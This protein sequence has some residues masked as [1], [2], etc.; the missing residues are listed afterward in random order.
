MFDFRKS[1]ATA[2]AVASMAGVLGMAPAEAQTLKVVMHS[3][4]KIL[5][6]IWTTAYIQ[7]NHGYMVWDTLF[8]M[9]EKFQAKPQMVDKYEVSADKLTWTI[10]LR[11][12]LVWSD[13]TP[14]TSDD[15][16][17]SIKRWGARDAFGQALMKSTGELKKVDDKSFAIVL[18]EP[19]GLVLEAL[20]K[21]SSNVPF[22]MPKRV[23]ETDPYK[24]ITDYTGSGP[25]I[26][27]KDEWKPGDKVVFVKNPK[28][29]P[30]SEPPSMLA[31]GKVA[32][33]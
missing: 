16:I 13:G 11:D 6:P 9:D 14:V 7:R 3:D 10:T 33:V 29:K 25:F 31:G 27:K 1:I 17:A 30:R 15:C 21:I 26:F 32:K 19:F 20:G 18:K 4:L 8:A 12:G 23:A 2:V 5:D 24:Q 28:Y 22:M